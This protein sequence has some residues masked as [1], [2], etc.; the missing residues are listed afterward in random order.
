MIV[1]DGQ[2]KVGNA[3]NSFS[4]TTVGPQRAP[5]LTAYIPDEVFGL[6]LD[7]NGHPIIDPATVKQK[8]I[9]LAVAKEVT[10]TISVGGKN[11][12]VSVDPQALAAGAPGIV[13]TA[14]QTR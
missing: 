14:P 9:N 6:A 3:I 11:W 5:D 12:S 4:M 10:R 2:E 13:L 1:K 8:A 7:P